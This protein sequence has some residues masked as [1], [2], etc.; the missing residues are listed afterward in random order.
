V[1]LAAAALEAAEWQASESRERRRRGGPSREVSPLTGR[2]A[3]GPAGIEVVRD[4]TKLHL[5]SFCLAPP[6]GACHRGP[7]DQVRARA[8]HCSAAAAPHQRLRLLPER[9]AMR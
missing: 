2:F 5:A 7:Q 1:E 8:R 3:G 6:R 4:G 9:K